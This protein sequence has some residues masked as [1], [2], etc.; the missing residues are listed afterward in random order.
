MA[1]QD[2]AD[3]TAYEILSKYHV[4]AVV[5]CS[6]NEGKP[7]H[8]VPEYMQS[9]GYKIVPVN[10]SADTIL[11]EK[12]YK[13]LLDIKFPVDVVDV[14]RPSPETPEIARQAVQIKAK[15]LWLQEGIF[16]DEAKKIAEDNGLLFIMNRCM[17]KEHYKLF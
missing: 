13:S 8:D 12:A 10:P 6:R 4:I 1:T 15:V 5:G 11:G 2:E 3:K 17:M 7:S 9:A 16:N 14:F